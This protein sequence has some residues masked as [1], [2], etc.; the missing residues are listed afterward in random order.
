M[1]I[2]HKA[3]GLGLAAALIL[4]GS[5]A[6]FAAAAFVDTPLNVRA[7]ASANSP[8]VDVLQRGDRVEVEFCQGT[9]CAVSKPGPDGWVSARYLS[10]DR[11]FYDDDFY[12]D[13]YYDEPIYIERPRRV[14]PRYRYRSRYD[15]PSFSACVGGPNARFCV[16]D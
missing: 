9:W 3:L 4:G 10:P 13:D 5:T 16:Y 14:F 2:K 7:S 8:I 15:D 6:A 12:D 1:S 11:G